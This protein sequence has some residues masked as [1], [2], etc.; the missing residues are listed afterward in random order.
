MRLEGEH[1][2]RRPFRL[3]QDDGPVDELLMAE[4][5]PVEIADGD[6]GAPQRGGG[7]VVAGDREGTRRRAG[8]LSGGT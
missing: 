1:G 4:M 8:L 6:D 2:A 5:E 7:R 3:R